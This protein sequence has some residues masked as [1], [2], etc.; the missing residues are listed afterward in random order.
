VSRDIWVFPEINS[1][2][3]DLTRLNQ[4]L[5]GE[6]C[7]IAEIAGG[8]VTAIICTDTDLD[9]SDL[10]KQYSLSHICVFKHPLLSCFSAELCA[11]PIAEIIKQDRP[12]LF[13]MGNT[14]AGK[15]LAARLTALVDT[16]LVTNCLKMDLANPERP[17]FYR[18]VYGGQACEEL[19]FRTGNTMLVTMD[20]AV[21]NNTTYPGQSGVITTVIKPD[22]D[23]IKIK[24][25][26]LA[27]LPADFKTV[28][29]AEADIVVSAGMGAISDDLLPMVNELAELIE[30]AIGTTRPVVDEGKIVRERMIGQ[31][32]KIVSPELYL[33]LGI[34]GASHHLGGI[35]EAGSIVSVNRDPLAPIFQNSDLGIVA[36]LKEVLPKLIEKIRQA[37]KDGKIL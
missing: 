37:K 11:P 13:L 19:I 10:S 21:L 23:N 12:W 5:L 36:D 31:T 2:T 3:E 14:T 7:S 28:D 18:P 1:R 22:L 9:F 33:A 34:S 27:Y 32:G 20:P 35:Q 24:M 4:G 29:I 16:G 30:G 25:K 8:R 17:L 6:A 26:H 15:E